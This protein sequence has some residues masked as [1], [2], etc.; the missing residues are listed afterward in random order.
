[1]AVLVGKRAVSLLSGKKIADKPITKEQAKKLL[2]AGKTGLIKGFKSKKGSSFDAF[3]K[4]DG[5]NISF[6][7][8]P[9]TVNK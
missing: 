9:K 1:M 2:S 6:D 8:P 4:L 7:F 5:S 3:L